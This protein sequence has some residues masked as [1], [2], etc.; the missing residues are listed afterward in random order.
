MEQLKDYDIVA[1]TKL[2]ITC[3]TSKSMHCHVC[4]TYIGD[5]LDQCWYEF[6]GTDHNGK[7]ISEPICP[8]CDAK[9]VYPKEPPKFPDED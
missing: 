6:T 1:D 9:K 4:N 2:G 3:K 8:E 7:M 5:I